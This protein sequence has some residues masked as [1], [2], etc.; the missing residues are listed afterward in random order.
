[1]STIAEAFDEFLSPTFTRFKHGRKR[2][3]EQSIQRL[4]EKYD[5]PASAGSD[6][7]TY[8]LVEV[9]LGYL[10]D[11]HAQPAVFPAAR[12][13]YMSRNGRVNR[14]LTRAEPTDD[15]DL[16]PVSSVDPIVVRPWEEGT[17]ASD[18]QWQEF[19]PVLVNA[20]GLSLPQNSR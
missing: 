19:A 4:S 2:P 9:E 12:M 7:T 13:W 17:R 11:I 18:H 15:G 10:K 6:E 3:I 16:E 20:H 1:M 5:T 8:Y 14:C